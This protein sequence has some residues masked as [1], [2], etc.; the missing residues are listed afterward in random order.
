MKDY[1]IVSDSCCDLEKALRDKYSIEYIPMSFTVGEKKYPASLDWEQIPAKQF[2]DTIRGGTRIIT[3]QVTSSQFYDSFKSYLD[4]GKDVLYVSCSSALSGSYEASLDAAE[5][6]SALYP[7]SNIICVDGLNSCYG[8]GMLCISASELRGAG[9]SIDEVA[10]WV[11]ENR[12]YVN[13]ECCVDKLTYLKMAGRVSASSAFFGGLLNI[14]PILISD[15]KGQNVAIEKV[16]GKKNALKRTAERIAE[17]YKSLPYQHVFISHS[18][19]AEEAE[20][21]KNIVSDALPDKDID[22]HI[23][24]IGPIVGAS[25]GPG[26]V[27]VFCYG[28]KVTYNA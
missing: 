8:L 1:V 2:Y 22:I 5:K 15:A 26:T 4:E 18:D 6:L 24:Y 16:K 7:D 21:F 10:E 25:V 14:K 13:Q 23:G 12:F 3:S 28:E 20:E 9:K 11:R 19:C 17:S 27:A